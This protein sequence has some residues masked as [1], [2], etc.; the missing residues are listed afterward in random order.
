MCGGSYFYISSRV[1][2]SYSALKYGDEYGV[3]TV[4]GNDCEYFSWNFV[5][6]MWTRECL[7]AD[8]LPDA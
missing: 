7:C 6:F 2:T 4:C 5:Y 1:C 3:H 8:L